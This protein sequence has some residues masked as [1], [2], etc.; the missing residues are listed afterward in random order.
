MC[1]F[2]GLDDVEYKKVAAALRRIA[3]TAS[4][5]PTSVGQSPLSEEQK[6]V[7]LY[8]LKF[9][10][11]DARQ[12]NIKKAH[13]KTCQWLL[14]TPDYLDWLDPSK[15]DK[16]HGFL[17][18][19]GKP[20][21]GK[22]TLMKFALAN[23][24]KKKLKDEIV[25]SFF[26]NARG[27]DL[28]KST[29]GM[30]RSLLLQLLERRPVFQEVFN[31]LGL[32]TWNDGCHQWS[33]EALKALFE[34]VVLGLG[35]LPVTCFIDAL[36]ECDEGQIRDMISVFEHVGEMTTTAKPPIRF[37][38]CFSS[39]HYPHITIARDVHFVLEGQEEHSKDI[40]RYLNSELKIGHSKLAEQIR[41]DLQEKASGVFMWVVLVVEILNKEHDGGRIRALRQRLR[42]IP[43]DLHNLFRDILM[44][45]HHNRGELLLCIQWVL[46]ARQPLKP[47]HLYFAILSGVDPDALSEW[48]PDEITAAVMKRFILNSSKG[49]AEV[50]KSKSPTV[51]FIHES[52]KDFLLKENGLRSIWSDLGGNFEGAS[53]ERLKQCCLSYMRID[54]ATS[55]KIAG[56]LPTANTQEAAELRQSANNRFPFLEYATRNVLYHAD[57]AEAGG[58]SQADFLQ[59][60]QLADWIKLDNLFERHEVR[61]HK[62]DASLL[63]ILAARDMAALIKIHPLNWSFFEEEKDERYGTPLF[64]AL[65]TDSNK[66][67]EAFVQVCLERQPQS[68]LGRKFCEQFLEKGGKSLKVGRDFTFSRKRGAAYHVLEQND[69]TFLAVFIA[70]R[71]APKAPDKQASSWAAV[72]NY[73]DLVRLMLET[74]Q[75]TSRMRDYTDQTLLHWAAE[76]G[77]DVV[78]RLLLEASQFD[79]DLRDFYGR[80]PLSLAAEGRHEVVVRLLLQTRRVDIN[81]KSKMGQTPLSYAAENG[82]HGAVQL[83]LEEG[84]DIDS[85]D[86]LDR[87]P[88][89]WAAENGH[90]GTIQLLLEKDADIESKHY[91]GRTPLSLAA[92][93]GH[94]TIV[95]LLLKKDADIESKDNCDQTPLSWAA[96]EGHETIVQL[97]LKKDADIESK[98][99][100]GRT[101]LSWAAGR[102]H[103]TIVQLL[104]GKDADIE[105]KDNSGLTPLSPIFSP[106]QDTLQPPAY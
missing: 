53:Q 31:S 101:P 29:V 96:G 67:V 93:G 83:L 85:K 77:L 14:D 105:S 35:E 41:A 95:Q 73:K 37:Q 102:G 71:Q 39:R 87:T 22:S 58:I 28:E 86:D 7:L 70:S 61:R 3:T 40:A 63:Y 9:D 34:E 38:V 11:L 5:Q 18:I 104:L 65:A 12:M 24:Q 66:A 26:F 62:A 90:E 23:A 16:H 100:S 79:G 10:Q 21:T 20:G 51:Q 91:S 2:T 49:L 55:L 64:A 4:R 42:D 81:S 48:D 19:K 88:L 59:S 78:V 50:T 15:R 60:F 99:N 36:D 57:A 54:I 82:N 94:E 8:S 6:R 45:D 72:Q 98:D 68:S 44:R 30:Y 89:S 13:A 25:I 103:E 56:S 27:D 1:R 47:E 106:S 17:W 92:G 33:I 75:A 43:G 97:L 80:T 46:F 76:R 69:E 52:V 74:Y 84:A 32:R